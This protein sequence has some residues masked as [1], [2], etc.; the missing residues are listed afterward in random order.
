MTHRRRARVLLIDAS[1]A[2]PRIDGDLRDGGCAVEVAPDASTVLELVAASSFDVALLDVATPRS[3]E[4]LDALRA[5]DIPV[6]A[7]VASSPTRPAL[8]SETRDHLAALLVDPIASDALAVAIDQAVES[9]TSR[10][11][12]AALRTRAEWLEQEAVRRRDLQREAT[13]KLAHDVRA[14]LA[15]VAMALPGLGG[16]PVRDR[17]VGLAKQAVDRACRALELATRAARE[18]SEEGRVAGQAATAAAR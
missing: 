12:V 8:D 15:V 10:R 14:S 3:R 1:G 2:R 7:L 5:R 9:T 16:D 11:S 18:E 6:I 13:S 17:K 4:L